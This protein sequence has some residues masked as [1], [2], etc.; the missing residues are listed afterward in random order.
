MAIF[1]LIFFSAEIIFTRRLTKK[2]RK[3]TEKTRKSAETRRVLMPDNRNWIATSSSWTHM[4]TD[5][6]SIRCDQPDM[7][8][9][10]CR[11]ISSFIP[12]AASTIS[13]F[14][15][16]FINIIRHELTSEEE[17]RKSFWRSFFL[18]C[19][20]I[21]FQA[22]F[23]V[24]YDWKEKN[25]FPT[26]RTPPYFASLFSFPGVSRANQDFFCL[27]R[28]WI[29][30]ITSYPYTLR[31][32]LWLTIK[33]ARIHCEKRCYKLWFNVKLDNSARAFISVHLVL[34]I[35]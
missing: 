24:R 33:Q 28:G 12:R 23:S 5:M 18:L 6:F 35:V 32:S 1:L 21:F 15:L 13:L 7:A 9:N 29:S 16:L 19:C 22:P 25:P 3:L 26:E 14:P 34:W 8:S 27:K 10:H 17:R 30:C 2:T 4:S 31:L 20:H 11:C